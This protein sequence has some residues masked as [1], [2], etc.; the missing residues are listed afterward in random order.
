ML[1][2]PILMGIF[3]KRQILIH[4]T[5]KQKDHTVYLANK[6][7]RYNMQFFLFRLFD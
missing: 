2:E 6:K 4:A 3:M 5:Q 7:Y 1:E